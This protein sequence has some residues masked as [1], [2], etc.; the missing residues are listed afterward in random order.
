MDPQPSLKPGEVGC[1]LSHVSLWERL[2]AEDSFPAMIMEDDVSVPNH[3]AWRRDVPRIA[4][5]CRSEDIE[6]VFQG[7]CYEYMTRETIAPSLPSSAGL[8]LSVFPQCTHAYML[9]RGG[10]HKLVAWARRNPNPVRAI[11]VELADLVQTGVLRSV[12]LDP[13]LAV[14]RGSP[15]II[16]GAST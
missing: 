9:S 6:I 4:C 7:H 5:L 14:Q 8:R 10:A 11:D 3:D 1:F 2:V 13:P 15:S 16:N 12:S